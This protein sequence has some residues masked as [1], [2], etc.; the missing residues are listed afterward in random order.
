MSGKWIPIERPPCARAFAVSVA[1]WA[2]A[3]ARTMDSPRPCWGSTASDY[4][5]SRSPKGRYMARLK[6]A[7]ETLV[8]KL[9]AQ[10]TLAATVRRRSRRGARPRETAGSAACLQALIAKS[11]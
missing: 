4:D 7:A 3:L 9:L 6:T 5:P 8:A 1:S 11:A 2:M 10:D